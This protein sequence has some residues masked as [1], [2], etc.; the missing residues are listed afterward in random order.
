ML[1]GWCLVDNTGDE[2]WDRVSLTLVRFA[3]ACRP[4]SWLHLVLQVGGRPNSF[5]HDLY[6]PRYRKRPKLQGNRTIAAQLGSTVIHWLCL[7]VLVQEQAPP[8]PP[9]LE[10]VLPH[11]SESLLRTGIHCFNHSFPL[12]RFAFCV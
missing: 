9:V 2:D 10:D 1:T 6:S 3:D 8:K 4:F 7:H 5:K 11:H 12:N